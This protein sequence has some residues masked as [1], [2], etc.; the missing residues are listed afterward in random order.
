[1]QATSIARPQSSHVSRS[2]LVPPRF[3]S[4]GQ[5]HRPSTVPVQG[6]RR[7]DAEVQADISENAARITPRGRVPLRSLL[8]SLER[9]V[10][11]CASPERVGS[12]LASK[13]EGAQ[14]PRAT[15]A[16][17]QRASSGVFDLTSASHTNKRVA[18]LYEHYTTR[19][20]VEEA[21]R[22]TPRT[23]KDMPEAGTFLDVL[24]L[25][26]P[27]FSRATLEMMVKDAKE[28]IDAIDRRRFVARAKGTYADRLRLAFSKSDSDSSGELGIDEFVDAVMRVGASPPGQKPMSKDQ[29]ERLF[30]AADTD[31]SGTLD[32]NEFLELCAQQPWLVAAF[33]RIVDAGVRHR[34]R[35]EQAKLSALF[36]HPVS[37]IS[38]L[39]I[40][41]G[42]RRRRPSLFNLRPTHEV[43]D[44]LARADRAANEGA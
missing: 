34:L 44:T 36:R 10:L 39:V 37:P 20:E 17:S 14:P 41:P 27:S 13:L 12:N 19:L 40:S 24:K 42:G 5:A 21:R 22:Q 2:L 3:L 11:Q 4:T 29:V 7:L 43:A 1:M 18:E 38:R 25:Y 15:S 32:F 35:D 31:S 23:G 26:Y 16:R 33:E 8:D 9:V 30:A 28:A 6:R